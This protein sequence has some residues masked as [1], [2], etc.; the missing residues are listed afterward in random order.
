VIPVLPLH[1]AVTAAAAVALALG[2]R[3][4]PLRRPGPPSGSSVAARLPVL[5]GAVDRL[6]EG[7]LHR[8]DLAGRV[9]RPG[10]SWAAL[11][12]LAAVVGAALSG[13]P[14]GLVAAAAAVVGPLV[15]LQL[16]GDRVPARI[17]RDLP[18][19]L[20]AVAASLR[21][22]AGMTTALEEGCGSVTGSPLATDVRGV[23]ADVGAGVT[24]GAA[25]AR[26]SAA[27]DQGEVRLAA[28]ALDLAASLGGPQA[29]TVDELAAV[30]RERAAL[31]AEVRVQASQA[32]ASAL[33]VG[34]APVAFALVVV[35]LD[36]DR[37]AAILSTPVGAVS[38]ALG[39]LLDAVG[40]L[41]MRHIV[42]D[43]EGV[44]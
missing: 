16:R 1:P 12:G 22:G 27:R 40:V 36:P 19:L 37:A 31:E 11:I 26:W 8:A 43:A 7:Y 39:L 34:V 28:S 2:V 24:L 9:R 30:L 33:L 44:S 3:R 10:R 6:L 35:L 42:R 15:L 18:P 21:T 23:V 5:A 4:G 38:I 17:R 25:L 32:R 20:E 14:G 41:W 13:P 29:R